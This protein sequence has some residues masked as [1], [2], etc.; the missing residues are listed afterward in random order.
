LRWILDHEAVSCIIPGASR[1]EQVVS[2]ASVSGLDP[3]PKELHHQLYEFYL[4]EIQ[5]NIRGAY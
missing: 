1:P 5:A 2:N 4:D 3:L